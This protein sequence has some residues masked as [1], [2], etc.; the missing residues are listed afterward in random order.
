MLASCL[1]ALELSSF[2]WLLSETVVLADIG[3]G[4]AIQPLVPQRPGV[5]GT[6]SAGP[7]FFLSYAHV[8]KVNVH[9]QADPDS[10]VARFFWDVCRS[11]VHISDL[12]VGEGI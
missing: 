5:A 12:P 6:T 8:P 3:R 9:D 7:V 4:H 2:G 10:D 11:L 1:A